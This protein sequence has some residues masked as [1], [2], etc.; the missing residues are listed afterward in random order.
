[1][2]ELIEKKQKTIVIIVVIV[3]IGIA[4]LILLL[5][6]FSTPKITE[7]QTTTTN[8]PAITTATTSNS[9]F[10]AI[11]LGTTDTN[12]V[13]IALKPQSVQNNQLIVDFTLN[14]HSVNLDTVDLTKVITLAYDNK[15]VYPSTVPELSGHHSSGK[16]VFTVDKELTKFNI[17]ITT[18][19]RIMNR[20]YSW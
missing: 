14:T 19:P 10:Q 12:D 18:I 1:M 17:T 16:I 15:Q 5:G 11:T 20:V 2:N 6:V 4:A 3:S 8:S 9:P 7:K 13:E